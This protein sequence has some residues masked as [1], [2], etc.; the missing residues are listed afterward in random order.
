M[1]FR[2]H[3]L[4]L[5]QSREWCWWLRY[6]EAGLIFRWEW[7]H[8]GMTWPCFESPWANIMSQQNCINNMRVSVGCV[9]VTDQCI[10]GNSNFENGI[11]DC[12][13]QSCSAEDATAAVDYASGF[14]L[15]ATGAPT[16]AAEP[17][18]ETTNT[19]PPPTTTAEPE[20]T[21]TPTAASE[22]TSASAETAT[23]ETETSTASAATTETSS[24]VSRYYDTGRFH[25]QVAGLAGNCWLTNYS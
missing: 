11:R 4:G 3:T 13:N 10:C 19:P 16:T 9:P 17:A 24:T 21:T 7:R 6:H 18:P 20:T 15:K 23:S 2:F 25:L 14:C 5:Y 1:A 8:P 12:A 22:P